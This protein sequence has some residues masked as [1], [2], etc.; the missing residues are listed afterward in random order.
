MNLRFVKASALL[1]EASIPHPPSIFWKHSKQNLQIE[2]SGIHII[3]SDDGKKS[4][5]LSMQIAGE[6]ARTKKP[7]T[8]TRGVNPFTGIN[9]SEEYDA[10]LAQEAKNIRVL[11]LN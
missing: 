8:P 4:V 7:V 1:K 6:I 2:A 5:R 3:C 9:E 10:M 11:Y